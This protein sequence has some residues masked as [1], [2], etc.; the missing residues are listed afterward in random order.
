MHAGRGH[1]A[2]RSPS[3]PFVGVLILFC[4]FVPSTVLRWTVGKGFVICYVWWLR[5]PLPQEG[6][7]IGHRG[8]RQLCA[9][10]IPPFA[11]YH[12]ARPAT[13]GCCQGGRRQG[14]RLQR[15]YC[16]G[17]QTSGM[18]AAVPT[19]CLPLAACA[20]DV[21]HQHQQRR[22]QSWHRQSQRGGAPLSMHLRATEH[23]QWVVT[24][25]PAPKVTPLFGEPF[26]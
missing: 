12:L 14:S 20:C 22:H 11:R 4:L 19:P 5:H 18:T 7:P 17:G 21:R 3:P 1:E 8:Q 26:K 6:C 10:G 9:G 16:N 13:S 15:G 2:V 24:Q 23:P 25:T